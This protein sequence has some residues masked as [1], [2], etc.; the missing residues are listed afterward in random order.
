MKTI[1]I[2]AATLLA[3]IATSVSAQTY[4]YDR[5]YDRSY[6]RYAD[7]GDRECFNPRAGHFERVRPGERQEDLDFR[8][9]RA[10]GYSGFVA[11]EQPVYRE[12][13]REWREARREECWNPRA[14][15]YEEVRPGERQD[16]LD[17]GR[18][19]IFRG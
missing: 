7:A 12:E 15:H 3:G 8:R 10:V 1:A 5:G 9:C 2:A 4:Y 11:E 18:C 6:D 13:R 14:R 17:Y 16:D 19:R